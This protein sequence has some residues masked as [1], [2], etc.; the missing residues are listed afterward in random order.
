MN[1]NKSKQLCC[2]GSKE[3]CDRNKDTTKMENQTCTCQK[4]QI[5]KSLEVEEIIQ[6]LT[7]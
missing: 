3:H 4:S 2:N 1:E 5:V 6:K 7:I